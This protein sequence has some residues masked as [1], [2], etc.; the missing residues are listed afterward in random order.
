VISRAELRDAVAAVTGM[1]PPPD[2]DE[3]GE[4]RARLA[5]RIALVS[6][7]LKVLTEVGGR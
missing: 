1:V 3:Y 4:T 5:A 2:A 7:S 6:G